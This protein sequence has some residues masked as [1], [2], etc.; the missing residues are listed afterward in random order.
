MCFTTLPFTDNEM[1]KSEELCYL[2]AR[3]QHCSD[4]THLNV[5]IDGVVRHSTQ[6]KNE[7]FVCLPVYCDE[8]RSSIVG[9]VTV[10]VDNGLT[11]PKEGFSSNV[12]GLFSS[13]SECQQNGP[14]FAVI[15]CQSQQ[16]SK[17]SLFKYNYFE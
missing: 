12:V 13:E 5:K 11:E 6:L 16:E 9:T 2:R 7:E 4:Q 14:N 1:Q 10:V 15:T 8:S 17:C 3:L